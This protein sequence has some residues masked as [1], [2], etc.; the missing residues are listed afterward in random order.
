M[1]RYASQIS[2]Y[3]IKTNTVLKNHPLWNSDTD[4]AFRVQGS[5]PLETFVYQKCHTLLQKAL[6][7]DSQTENDVLTRQIQSLGFVTWKH[8]DLPILEHVMDSKLWSTPI[9]AL[10]RI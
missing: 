7:V 9:H 10:Y 6:C 8:L 2:S 3:L 5:L 1:K 4:D